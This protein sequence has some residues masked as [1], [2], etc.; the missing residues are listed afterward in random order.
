M[1]KSSKTFQHAFHSVNFS[2]HNDKKRKVSDNFK[3]NFDVIDRSDS[4]PL[5]EEYDNSEGLVVSQS[6]DE[7]FRSA[8]PILLRPMQQ[9]LEGITK[10]YSPEV[11][12]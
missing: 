5:K 9:S 8:Q 12:R 10:T 7:L 11:N 1:L 2:K 4:I 6:Q 3:N